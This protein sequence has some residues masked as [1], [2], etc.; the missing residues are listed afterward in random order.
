MQR[1]CGRPSGLTAPRPAPHPELEQPKCQ[2]EL[3]QAKLLP[4]G[5]QAHVRAAWAA[6]APGP[7]DACAAGPGCVLSCRGHQLLAHRRLPFG[8]GW[9]RETNET[10]GLKKGLAADSLVISEQQPPKLKKY[11]FSLHPQPC[12]SHLTWEQHSSRESPLKCVLENTITL[13]CEV[14]RDQLCKILGK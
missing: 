2:A 13:K 6:R 8:L 4:S 1:H 5:E 11:G 9:S 14:W 12:L 3:G 7:S 10:C